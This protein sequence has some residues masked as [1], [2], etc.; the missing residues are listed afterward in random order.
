MLLTAR[1]T[2]A[3][4]LVTLRPMV[5]ADREPLYLIAR[6]RLLWEQHQCA[7]RHERPVFDEFFDDGLRSL[8]AFTLEDRATGRVIGG[9]RIRELNSEVMEIGWT[10]LDRS[11]WGT[12]YNKSM[13]DLLIDYIFGLEMDVLFYVNEC[14]LRSQKAVGKLGAEQLLDA[15]HPL[16]STKEGGLTFMLR[17]P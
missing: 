8:K 14:N 11:L 6:D 4:D 10:F 16:F 3:N 2:L 1:P 17:R 13:K 9:T 15:D 12:D 7:D 5:P